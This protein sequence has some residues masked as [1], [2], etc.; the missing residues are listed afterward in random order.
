MCVYAL[1]SERKMNRCCSK[2]EM[3]KH[4][5]TDSGFCMNRI[6]P[7]EFVVKAEENP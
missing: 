3:F 1:V 7:V 2:T 5:E 4:Y 6:H